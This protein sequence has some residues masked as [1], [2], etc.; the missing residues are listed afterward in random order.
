MKHNTAHKLSELETWVQ[1]KRAELAREF[2]PSAARA[3]RDTQVTCSDVAIAGV[4]C[5]TVSPHSGPTGEVVLYCFGGGY[6]SGCPEFDLPITAQLAHA[7]GLTFIAPRYALAPEPPYPAALDEVEGVL[8]ALMQDR[9]TLIGVMGES[10]GG[11][12]LLAALARRARKGMPLPAKMVFC[13]PWTDLRDRGMEEARSVDDPTLTVDDLVTARAIY[14]G[15]STLNLEISPSGHLP[16]ARWPACF[17][18]TGS[19]D[20]L[21]WQTHDLKRQLDAHG[22]DVVFRDVPR[23]H[24]VFEVYDDH[25]ASRPMLAAIAEWLLETKEAA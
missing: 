17:L 3:L 25:T 11:G 2:Q 9:E 1:G 8:T 14:R 19:D 18:T 12:L 10:A 20:I 4:P 21:R 22:T 16:E 6:F 5:Q 15:T 13:S 23:A 7:T 24:H